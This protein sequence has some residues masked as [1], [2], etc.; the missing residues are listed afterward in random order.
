[1]CYGCWE[2]AGKPAIVNKKTKEVARLVNKIYEFSLSGGEAHVVVDDWNLDNATIN[3]NLRRINKLLKSKDLPKSPKEVSW[4]SPDTAETI[5]IA[6]EALLA[7]KK[8]T[9][10]ERYTV[11]AIQDGHLKI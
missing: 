1:M 5:Q 4:D 2:K 3:W 11:L 10:P 6:K 9:E 7:L 8:L